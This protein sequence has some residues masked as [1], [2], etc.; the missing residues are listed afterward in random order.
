MGLLIVCGYVA[1]SFAAETNSPPASAPSFLATPE[2]NPFGIW[3]YMGKMP[4]LSRT[5]H[6]R[7][8]LI[9]ASWS[10]LEPTQGQWD[11][12]TLD[13]DLKEAADHKLNLILVVFSGSNSPEWI[14][15]QGVPAV[16]TTGVHGAQK[17]LYPYYLNE[18]YKKFF[19]NMIVK[20]RQHVDQLPP[21]VRQHLLAVQAGF[22]ST[23]DYGPYHGD[24]IEKKYDIKKEDWMAYYKEMSTFYIQQYKDAQPPIRLLFNPSNDADK[25]ADLIEWI[26]TNS[27]HALIKA[28]NTGHMYQING[29]REQIE[30]LRSQLFRKRGNDFLRVRSEFGED[31]GSAGWREAPAWNMYALLQAGLYTGLDIECIEGEK[32][33]ADPRYFPAFEFF[34]RYAGLKDPATCPGAFCALRDGL[35][36]SDTKRFPESEFGP[37]KLENADRA[38]KIAKAYAKYGAM[39]GNPQGAT[40]S[41][42]RSRSFGGI[43]D[44]GWQI[45]TGNYEIFLRQLNTNE[46][47]VG[48]WRVGPKNQPYGRYAR[49]FEHAS[50]KDEMTFELDKAFFSI[51]KD[52]NVQVRVV[53]F[54]KGAGKWALQY[55][56]GKK[57]MEVQ[58]KDTGKWQ[59]VLIPLQ[60]NSFSGRLTLKNVDEEDDIFEI[61]EVRRHGYE[62]K[63]QTGPVELPEEA[64]TSAASQPTSSKQTDAREERRAQRQAEKA[65]LKAKATK[66]AGL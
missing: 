33:L 46:T 24:L 51:N 37:A 8:K 29:E 23:G 39:E 28:G 31:A 42:I 54:D 17:D 32:F 50:G 26:T 38:V 21:V 62:L 65:A 55:D 52:R 6:V 53:Y 61:V 10:D 45:Y 22:S 34:N 19:R 49:G 36:S 9:R 64:A 20:V 4:D 59:E 30:I 47:S 12:K 60:D 15:K 13:A 63:E 41:G 27:P 44:V 35:D 56:D 1:H 18:N 11:F 5:P 40:I 2:N 57:A 43:N 7:G 48:Y 66:K 3:D 58:K 16:R 25:S 14:Y